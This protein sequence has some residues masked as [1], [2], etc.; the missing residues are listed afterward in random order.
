MAAPQGGGASRRPLGLLFLHIFCMIFQLFLAV[1][2]CFSM[3][4]AEKIGF[5]GPFCPGPIWGLP[6]CHRA[7]LSKQGHKATIHKSADPLRGRACGRRLQPLFLMPT[8]LSILFPANLHT[9]IPRYQVPRYQVTRYRD[10]R[11]HIPRYQDAKMPR[12]VPRCQD[13]KIP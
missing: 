7:L 4:S 6:T 1:L 5:P 8:Y 2:L 9:K 10:A 13:A 12:C 11:Y 3:I